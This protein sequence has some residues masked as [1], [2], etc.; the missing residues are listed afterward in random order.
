MKSNLLIN[1]RMPTI[2]GILTFYE[3]DDYNIRLFFHIFVLSA[4]EV[5]TSGPGLIVHTVESTKLCF[6]L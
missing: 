2:V 4:N 1:V 5:I 3:Q 6:N